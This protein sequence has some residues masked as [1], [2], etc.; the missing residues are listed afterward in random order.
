MA[1]F[2][3]KPICL[4]PLTDVVK[5]F[6]Q[7]GEIAGLV[8]IVADKEKLLHFHADGYADIERGIMMRPDSLFWIASQTK[9]ITAVALM[10]L[11]D[12]GKV[13]VDAPVAEYLP[14][15]ADQW[16]IQQ[17][18]ETALMLVKTKPTLLVRHLLS[19]TSGLPFCTPVEWPTLDRLPLELASR[20]YA[21]TPLQWA[22]GSNYCYS[23]AGIN[24]VGRIIEKV[25]GI[26]YASFYSNAFSLR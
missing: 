13:N 3:N 25:S 7:R 9:P 17:E 10:M 8:T 19:H 21:M 6:L 5:P 1:K 24:S 11:V 26:E 12:E 23:N 14:E 15:F 22:P 4:L 16:M 20:S 18:D 2:N